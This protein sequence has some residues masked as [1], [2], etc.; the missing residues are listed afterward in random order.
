MQVI[1]LEKVRNKGS[2]GDTVNVR[3]GYFRNFLGPKKKAIP[4][5]KENIQVFEARKA[6]LEKIE[7]QKLHDANVR[8]QKFI[9]LD[10]IVIA[11]QATDEG[12]LFGSVGVRDIA[13]AIVA[14]GVDVHNSE[15]ALPSG[16]IRQTGEYELAVILH[17]DVSAP[18][19]VS[20][21]R[22]S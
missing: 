14:K 11:A 20:V 9:A 1:L 21:V 6:E 8:A 15:I 16:V 4:A 10:T 3:P 12:K 22:E 2:L 19:K 5:T 13:D 18:I 17:S 7:Q